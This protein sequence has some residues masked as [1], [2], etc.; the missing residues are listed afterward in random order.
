MP[1]VCGRGFRLRTI[2]QADAAGSRR[3]HIVINLSGTL[4]DIEARA[5][6][7]EI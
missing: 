6:G 4:A 5:N 2:G 1:D 3:R 7:I